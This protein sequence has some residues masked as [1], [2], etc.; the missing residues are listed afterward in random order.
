M[1]KEEDKAP[2]FKVV[3]SPRN[4]KTKNEGEQAEKGKRTQPPAWKM[5]EA[6]EQAIMQRIAEKIKD[7]CKSKEKQ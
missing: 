6:K 5:N 2:M 7:R 3:E 4:K 1:K